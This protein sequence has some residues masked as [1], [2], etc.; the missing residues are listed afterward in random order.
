MALT[1]LGAGWVGPS[2]LTIPAGTKGILATV[3]SDGSAT[4][5]LSLGGLTFTKS[6]RITGGYKSRAECFY[7]TDISGRANDVLSYT[8]GEYQI[9]LTYVG[10]D[11]ALELH[12]AKATNIY[13]ST[14][15]THTHTAPEASNLVV[16]GVADWYYNDCSLS[17]TLTAYV[18]GG[19]Y[20]ARHA[21]IVGA[22]V[23]SV[24]QTAKRASPSGE[25][26]YASISFREIPASG[27]KR[28]QQSIIIA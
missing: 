1:V 10:A 25:G 4:S 22:E 28:L 20:D 7:L 19:H 13:G 24:S 16:A 21:R 5:Q 2:T 26:V 8:G 6:A 18:D 27:G 15:Y 12:E 9:I 3:S 17:G 14:A 23:S 11:G